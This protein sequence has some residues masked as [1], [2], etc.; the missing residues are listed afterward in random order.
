MRLFVPALLSL[1]VPAA[2]AATPVPQR[3]GADLLGH[4]QCAP[5]GAMF[6]KGRESRVAPHR[7]DEEPPA[8]AY[9]AVLRTVQGCAI[10]AMMREEPRKGR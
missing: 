10:P 7:L 1:A 4:R 5:P 3:G 8:Q 6:A 9:L 2:F